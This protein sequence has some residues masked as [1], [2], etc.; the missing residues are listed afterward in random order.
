MDLP[1][2][3]RDRLEELRASL[4]PDL[5]RVGDHPVYALVTTVEDLRVFMDHHVWAVWDFM[6]LLKAIQQ[7]YTSTVLP[8]TPRGD[9]TLRRFI[10]EIVLEEESDR[11]PTD[12]YSSHFEIYVAAMAE[13]G[14]PTGTVEQFIDR[15]AAGGTFGESVAAS[16][17]APAVSDFLATTWDAANGGDAELVAAFTFG[18][19]T[20][21]PPMFRR[22]LAQ[23]GGLDDAGML[24]YYLE[25]HVELDGDSHSH[26]AEHLL[27]STCGDDAGAWGC[28]EESARR[29]L[30]ARSRLWDAVAESLTHVAVAPG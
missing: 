16:G 6:N 5:A 21:I 2:R 27:A 30:A 10:N 1:H 22:I 3:D 19:E 12:G 18:R 8:W 23:S 7:R 25:R 11:Q 4:A 15:L 14:A 26:L 28:A 13:V 17:C 9:A 29:C 24:R 20:V